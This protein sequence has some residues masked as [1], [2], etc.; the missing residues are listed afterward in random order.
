MAKHYWASKETLT[1]YNR[2]IKRQKREALNRRLKD[3]AP[4]KPV[5]VYHDNTPTNFDKYETYLKSRGW[6]KKKN[7]AL[8]RDG[9]RCRVCNSKSKLQVHHRTYERLYEEHLDDLTVLCE[10]CHT[11]FH[12]H[13]VIAR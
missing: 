11:L 10:K 6:Q 7:R 4:S 2:R 5:R 13:R 8:K 9:H 3:E 12:Q 1:Q